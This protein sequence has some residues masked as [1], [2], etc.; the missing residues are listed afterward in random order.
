[1]LVLKHCEDHSY[2]IL[3]FTCLVQVDADMSTEDLPN[4]IPMPKDQAQVKDLGCLFAFHVV[5]LSQTQQLAAC[6][7]QRSHFSADGNL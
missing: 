4:F 1:M 3:T 7:G 5:S 6:C 2:L